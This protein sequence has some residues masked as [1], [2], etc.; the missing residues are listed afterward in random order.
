MRDER[1][2][3]NHTYVGPVPS[4]APEIPILTLLRDRGST[5]RR[6]RFRNNRSVLLSVSRDGRT[7]NCHACFR[8]APPRIVEAI[9]DAVA[10]PRTSLRRRDALKRLRDW[11]GTLKGLGQ[12]RRSKAPRRRP[13]D[14]PETTP[15]RTLF[16]KLN[17][18]KFGGRLPD[19]PLRLSR[20]MTRSLGTVRYRGQG[21]N[22]AGS[23]GHGTSPSSVNDSGGRIVEEIAISTDLLRP[24]NLWLL[25]DTMLHEMAHAEAWIR[26]GHR[27]H[28]RIWKAI[29]RRVGCRPNAVNDV[30]V[31]AGRR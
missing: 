6:V 16:R 17:R 26:H 22:G 9:A 18:E 31:I 19:I 29:A 10:A 7:L 5:I 27:G 12:A 23:G 11:E 24:S 2:P 1:Q 14:T 21:E 30:R 20:R 3:A 8:E 28:G 15:L 13:V 25:E 4:S